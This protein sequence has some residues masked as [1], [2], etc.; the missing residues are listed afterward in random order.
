MEEEAGSLDA[1]PDRLRP[2]EEL[3]RLGDQPTDWVTVGH[4]VPFRP[5][6]GEW[7]LLGQ[8][9]RSA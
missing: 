3:S 9:C 4:M 8:M 1:L 2:D 5:V 6:W 7:P